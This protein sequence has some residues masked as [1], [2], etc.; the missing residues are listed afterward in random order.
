MDRRALGLVIILTAI[1]GTGPVTARFLVGVSGEIV[2]T[3]LTLVRWLIAFTFLFFVLLRKQSLSETTSTLKA[4]WRHF[5]AIGSAIAAFGLLFLFGVSLSSAT[6]AG[7]LTNVHPIWIVILAPIFLN[8][9]THLRTVFGILATLI[10]M[11]VVVTKGQFS[12]LVLSSEYL[13]GDLLLILS[14]LAW[15]IQSILAR[16][17]VKKYG[18][19]QTT[20]LSAPFA[21][22]ILVPFSLILGNIQTIF[23]VSLIGFLLILHFSLVISGVGY[24]LW[25]LILERMEATKAS[26]SIL[27]VPV[28]TI[29]FAYFFLNEAITVSV[30]GGTAFILAGIYLVQ[31]AK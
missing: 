1:W 10:G 4:D 21:I 31:T 8:E 20:V 11:L 30:I 6:N 27:I 14:A 25:Y 17:Y 12:S 22:I 16:K 5:L 23:S 13:V 24:V 7:L 19:L 2:P 15:A 29:I 9:K 18:G 28:Y 26:V 3:D